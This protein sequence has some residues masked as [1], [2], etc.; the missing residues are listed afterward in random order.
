MFPDDLIIVVE[1]ED[2]VVKLEPQPSVEIDAV[3]TTDVITILAGNVGSPGPQGKWTSMTQAE[4][5][6]LTVVDPDTL[7]VIIG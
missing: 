2:V 3:N 7:Y 4:F 5:D 6:A 1:K